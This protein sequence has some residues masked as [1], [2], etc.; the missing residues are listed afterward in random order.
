MG[1]RAKRQSDTQEDR[2]RKNRQCAK[3][4]GMSVP[5]FLSS[6]FK[7]GKEDWVREAA[8]GCTEGTELEVCSFSVALGASS[9]CPR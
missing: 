7:L 2:K 1:D 6:N 8:R 5:F 3:R 4:R 9:D